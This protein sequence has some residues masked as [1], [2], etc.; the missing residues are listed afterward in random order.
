MFSGLL[1][2]SIINLIKVFEGVEQ[3]EGAYIGVEVLE[4]AG[5]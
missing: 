2:V 4:L 5:V 3:L 1:I